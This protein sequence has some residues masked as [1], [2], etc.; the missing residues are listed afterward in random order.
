MW[1]YWKKKDGNLV[2]KWMEMERLDYHK[3]SL[4]KKKPDDRLKHVFL[5]SLQAATS[6][7]TQGPI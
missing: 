1:D 3:I 6:S 5:Q 7:C 4:K 2:R